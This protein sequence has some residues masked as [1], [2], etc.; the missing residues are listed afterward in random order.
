MENLQKVSPSQAPAVDLSTDG[1]TPSTARIAAIRAALLNTPYSICLERP[2]LMEE[3]QHSPEGRRSAKHDHPLVHRARTLHHILSRRKPRIYEGE[4]ISGNMTSKRIAANYFIEGGSINILEDVLRLE[5]RA[6][7]LK[8]TLGEKKELVRIGLANAFKS[9]GAKALFKPWRISYFLDFFRAKRHFVTEEAGVGHQV[10]D[11]RMVVHDGLKRPYEEAALRLEEG[12][13]KD[14]TPLDKDRLAFF[15]SVRITIDGIR[16]MAENLAAEAERLAA[17]PGMAEERIAELRETARVCRRV[18]FEPARTFQEGLQAVWLVHVALNLEDFEQGLSFGRMDQILLPLY[19]A[20]VE[21]GLITREQAVEMLASFC[22]KT[23]E[24]TPLYS[25][26]MDQFFSGNGVAQAFT[27]G[28]TDEY[29]K[30]V[31]N[32]LS[33]IILDAYSQVLTREPAVHVRIHPSTPTWFLRKSVELLQL[34]TS[35]P[36]FFGDTAVV[37]ALENA[38]MSRAHARD[39][40]VIGC[41]E[42]ASQGRTYNSSDAALFNLPLCLELALNE[43]RR[44]HGKARFEGLRRFGARTPKVS[45]M[46]TFDDVLR[47]FRAQVEHGVADMVKVI[48]WMEE[49]YRTVRTTPVNSILTQGCLDKG[50]D[51]TWGGGLYDYTSVQAAGLAD[52]GDSLYALRKVVFEDKRMS[53]TDFVQVLKDNFEGHEALRAELAAKLPRYGNGDPSVDGMTQVAADAFSHAVRAHRN[54]RGGRYVPGFYSMTCHLGFGRVTGALPNGRLAGQ[55]LSNGLAPSDGAERC[56]PTAVL[57]SAASLKS[58]KWA[59]C[60]A[61]NLKFDWSL[62]Q[63]HAARKALTSLFRNYFAQGGMQVQVNVLDADML[64]AARKDPA[65]YPGIVVRV[66]GYCAY[67]TDLQPDVQDEI[68]ERTAHGIG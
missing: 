33:G 9:V 25:E 41:V 10:G 45:S 62:V 21:S 2:R 27:L 22:L 23:C 35:R 39:Y 67:F 61:L 59:N 7:P 31:T 38:G 50:R 36:S 68:I 55:R 17:S 53:L 6:I 30:D 58:T 5:K 16:A 64:K 63:G 42:M 54:T 40:A 20:D 47:A 13:L 66:A 57:R 37:K 8:L 60:C 3:F 18:P 24:T 56:G 49:A 46:V 65:R 32:E 26:R 14:G 43:G 34:G 29:G 52:T 1:F 11:Y 4:L 19:R 12:R 28:G 48:G 51:V 15:N 44:F